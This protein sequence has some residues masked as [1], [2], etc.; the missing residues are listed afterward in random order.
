MGIVIEREHHRH[1]TTW[2]HCWA[3][4]WTCWWAATTAPPVNESSSSAS[5]CSSCTLYCERVSGSLRTA[6]ACIGE[7]LQISERDV[8][9]L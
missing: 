2:N 5:A 1:V 3:G 9:K 7:E 8:N 4:R 6:Y